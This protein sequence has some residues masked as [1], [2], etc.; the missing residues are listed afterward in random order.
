MKDRLRSSLPLKESVTDGVVATATKQ[1][2]LLELN[3][4]PPGEWAARIWSDMRTRWRRGE[5]IRVEAYFDA[6]GFPKEDTELVL[7][8]IYA[9]FALREEYG[10][11]P[12]LEEYISRFPQFRERL[13]RQF[14]VHLELQTV[15]DVANN[16]PHLRASAPPADSENENIPARVG[17]YPIL[18]LLGRGGQATVY[19]AFHPT[20]GKEVVI[21]LSRTRFRGST[22]ERDRLQTEGRILAELDHPH[23]AR[24]LDLDLHVGFPFLVMEF[25]QG[26]SL[27]QATCDSPFTSSQAASLVAG[28]A[29]AVGVAHRS[30]A[31]HQDIKPRNILVDENGCPH[32]I[33]FGLARIQRIWNQD[34]AACDSACGTLVFMAPEQARGEAD[35]ITSRTDIFALGG[36]LYFLLTGRAPFQA[37]TPAEALALAVQGR[38]ERQLLRVRKVPRRLRAI[39][40]RA[41]ATDPVERYSSADSLA[42]ELE[43][44]LKSW[45]RRPLLVAGAV[46]VVL[47]VIFAASWQP[48][49]RRFWAQDSSHSVTEAE[50]PQPALRI[51]VWGNDRYRDLIYSLP[52]QTGD[53]LRIEAERPAGFHAALLWV[54]PDGI[55]HVL[56]TA[57]PE[58]GGNTIVYPEVGQAV[59]L[60]G[61]PGTELILL[62]GRRDRP[63]DTGTLQ[64]KLAQVKE[65]PALPRSSIVR[66]TLDG[67]TVENTDRGPGQPKQQDDPEGTITDRLRQIQKDLREECEVLTGVVVSHR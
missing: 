11:T 10:D 66:L 30:G 26:R 36:V 43:A 1:L 9:E 47:V 44:A 56:A 65:W 59:P 61:R 45:K 38:W 62:C 37:S 31:V 4:I 42:S 63:I 8:L 58:D 15:S 39:C 17:K 52:L 49:A 54:D 18:A 32:L 51:R 2:L 21:K 22:T 12:Q 50:T 67:V 60:R 33:D 29:R 7:D 55:M 5:S 20:L 57:R 41:M 16:S 3:G 13:A 19:R 48:V 14:S 35:K 53:E 28:V 6:P 25:V 40:D 23:L 64:R 27:E 34:E 24:V 46:L